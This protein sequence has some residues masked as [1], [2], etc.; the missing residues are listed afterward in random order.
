[1]AAETD[2]FD[3][4]RLRLG[5]GEGRRLALAT[6]FAPLRFAD[7]DYT[8]DDADVILDISRMTGNGYSMRLRFETDV[9]GMCMRCLEDAVIHQAV[10]AREVNQPGGGDDL[11]SPY[12]DGKEELLDLVG[13]ARDALVLALPVQLSCPDTDACLARQ[14]A[15]LG[16]DDAEDGTRTESAEPE[17]DPR[18]AKLD[19]LKFD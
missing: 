12:L 19:E 9:R 2:T 8:A 13:W 16:T 11:T 1:M 6:S 10:D 5:A 18:W 14:R 15:M 3:I 7:V 17:K 4:G